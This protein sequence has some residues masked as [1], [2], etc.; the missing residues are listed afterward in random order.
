[1]Q[2]PARRQA[3]TLGRLGNP[4]HSPLMPPSPVRGGKL[5]PSAGRHRRPADT[6]GRL[7]DTVGR[8]ADIV[9]R[10]R[11]LSH[12]GPPTGP[13]GS[14]HTRGEAVLEKQKKYVPNNKMYGPRFRV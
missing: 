6:V 14:R 8:L 3:H 4:S 7:A 13:S 11:N 9:G 10:L 12:S 2:V 5:P 1:M